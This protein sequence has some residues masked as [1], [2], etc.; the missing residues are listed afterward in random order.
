[1]STVAP[2]IFAVFRAVPDEAGLGTLAAALDGVLLVLP[3]PAEELP[4]PAA[5]NAAAASPADASHL[6]GIGFSFVR[7]LAHMMS[8]APQRRLSAA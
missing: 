1:V 6:L 4:H 5:M 2:L 8:A 3:E 7:G